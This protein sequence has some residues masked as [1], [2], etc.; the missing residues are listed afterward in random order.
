MKEKIQFK[1]VM[2]DFDGTITEKGVASPSKDMIDALVKTAAKVPIAFCTGRQMTSFERHG[3]TEILKEI[4][5]TERE[6]FLQ[7]LFLFAENGAIGYFY[8]FAKGAFQEFYRASWPEN[9]VAMKKFKML[10]SETLRNIGDVLD[11]HEVV[12]VVR[13]L[14]RDEFSIE[15]IYEVSDRMYGKT[16][17]LLNELDRDYEKH[18]HIGNSGI[19]V[20]VCPADADKDR[21]IQEFANFLREKRGFEL[22]TQ[23]REILVIGD[24]NQPGGNDYYF[25][26]GDFG[27]PYT[28]GAHQLNGEITKPVLDK[29]KNRLLYATGTQ[30]LLKFLKLSS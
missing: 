13:P 10:L 9:F 6:I 2:F 4:S 17:E 19:G 15:D 12:V 16:K 28:V 14:R 3:L 8:D 5:E 30:Y 18:L 29:D 25:L 11:I 20:I 24:S 21:G 27:T 22:D 7:N 26:K 23:A 1:A